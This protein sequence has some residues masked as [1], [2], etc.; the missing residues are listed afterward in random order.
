MPMATVRLQMANGHDVYFRAPRHEIHQLVLN[1]HGRIIAADGE[2]VI[3]TERNVP[4]TIRLQEI[5]KIHIM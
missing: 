1:R 4:F 5:T 2:H 3:T